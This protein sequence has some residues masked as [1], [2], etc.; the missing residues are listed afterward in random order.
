MAVMREMLENAQREIER[1]GAPSRRAQRMRTP[2]AG[3]T[4]GC[5]TRSTIHAVGVSY[6][7]TKFLYLKCL[8]AVRQAPLCA[9]G[10]GAKSPLSGAVALRAAQGRGRDD[11]ADHLRAASDAAR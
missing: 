8:R 6:I 3:A 1:A 10:V 9:S 4:L 5:H 11:N 2:F 7:E